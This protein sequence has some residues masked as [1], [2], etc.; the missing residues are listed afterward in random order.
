MIA[1]PCILL[2]DGYKSVSSYTNDLILTFSWHHHLQMDQL[3]PKKV[4]HFVEVFLQYI[5]SF[6]RQSMAP[7]STGS[8]SLPIMS[9][10]PLPAYKDNPSIKKTSSKMIWCALFHSP[11]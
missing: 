9:S 7:N 1:L 5:K 11:T 10:V 2:I 4:V 8:Y 6:N 3:Q